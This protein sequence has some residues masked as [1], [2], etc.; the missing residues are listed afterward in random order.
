MSRSRSRRQGCQTAPSTAQLGETLR[1][2]GWKWDSPVP[3]AGAGQEDVMSL[4]QETVKAGD[5]KATRE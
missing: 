1:I 4:M 2:H 5:H 3:L